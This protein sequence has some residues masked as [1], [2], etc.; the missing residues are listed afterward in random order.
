MYNA[1]WGFRENPFGLSPDPAFLYRSMQHEEALGSLI[2][3]VQNREG[4]MVLTGDVGTGKTMILECLR[5]FL[6]SQAYEFA[7]LDNPRVTVDQF[8]EIIVYN[9]GLPCNRNAKAQVRSALDQLIRQQ[10]RQGR[11]TVLIVDEAQNLAAD[12]LEQIR[13]LGNRENP[14]GKLLQIVLS[15]QREFERRFNAPDLRDLKRRIA[16]HCRLVAFT[17][18]ETREYISMR[19]ERAGMPN[20]TVFPPNLTAEIH[21]R[22]QGI[23]RLINAIC[24]NLL[25]KAYAM[26]SR[27][28]TVEMLE[29]ISANMRLDYTRRSRSHPLPETASD[30]TKSRPQGA[31][32]SVTTPTPI[33]VPPTRLADEKSTPD[34]DIAAARQDTSATP[35]ANPI[36]T[37]ASGAETRRNWQWP[38]DASKAIASR[39]ERLRAGLSVAGRITMQIGRTSV[40]RL[41]EAAR[42]AMRISGE[43]FVRIGAVAQNAIR[44]GRG[45]FVRLAPVA[46]TAMRISGGGFVR[47]APVAHALGQTGRKPLVWLRVLAQTSGEADHR[48]LAWTGSAAAI[49]VAGI[50]LVAHF[51]KPMADW[52]QSP[53]AAI[54]FGDDAGR[55]TRQS[56]IDAVAQSNEAHPA[57]PRKPGQDAPPRPLR[58]V[59]AEYTAAARSARFQGPVFV[60]VTVDRLGGVSDLEFTTPIAFGLDA[61]VRDVAPRWRFKPALHDGNPVESRTI[62][63]VPFR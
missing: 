17:A 60:V 28:A 5:D 54:S 47:L 61:P 51:S 31:R 14:S 58:I 57:A 49:T 35:V 19:L 9:L 25:L 15:G 41:S 59:P 10:A 50:S 34:F 18:A 27:I 53:G 38:H 55:K 48:T 8:F 22:S 16:Q 1:F 23:P 32:P 44:T 56:Q 63:K 43:G 13:L 42:T 2:Q 36:G 39:S 40:V 7:F 45:S 20:Q 46:R 6:K 33:S 37:D 4:L 52:V 26:E 24:D 11:T 3:G 30:T 62:V 21:L 12:V 29:E